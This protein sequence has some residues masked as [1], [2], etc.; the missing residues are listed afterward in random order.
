MYLGNSV[1]PKLVHTDHAPFPL[2]FLCNMSSS[3]QCLEIQNIKGTDNIVADA[4]PELR[5]GDL[6]AL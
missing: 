4:F 2:L 3:N 1:V 5:D 6:T